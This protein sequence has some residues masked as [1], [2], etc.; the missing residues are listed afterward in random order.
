MTKKQDRHKNRLG[1]DVDVVDHKS[2]SAAAVHKVGETEDCDGD[3]TKFTA[4]ESDTGDEDGRHC[5]R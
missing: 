2:R 1:R 5:R 4:D 3:V